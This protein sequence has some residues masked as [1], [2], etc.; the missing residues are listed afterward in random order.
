V[1]NLGVWIFALGG[2][3]VSQSHFFVSDVPSLFWH[4]L[5]VYLLLLLI[6]Q[7]EK[8]SKKEQLLMWSAF[9]F[10]VAFGLK[11]FLV[12]LPSL[13]LTTMVYRIRFQKVINIALFFL[14]GFVI[15]N[16]AD[17]T[18]YIFYKTMV[19]GVS[20]P[21]Q[22]SR[23]SSFF[24]YV[25][26]L[27][28][29]V[30][31]PVAMLS[32]GGIYFLAKKLFIS[33][34]PIKYRKTVFI[35]IVPILTNVL[36]IVFK[37]D[38]F[39]R[40]LI[41]LIPWMSLVAG[42]S[43]VQIADNLRFKGMPA[44]LLIIL[45]FVYLAVFIFDAERVFLQEPRN[46]AA[47]WLQHNIPHGTVISWQGHDWLKS[48]KHVPFPEMGR[49]QVIVMEMHTANHYLSGMSWKDSY[50]ED[51]RFIFA[52]RSQE[53]VDAI[54]SLFK[55]TSEYR[56]VIKFS[57]GYFMPEYTLVDN[58]IGNRSRNYIAEIVIFM[59]TN[60]D[61]LPQCTTQHEEGIKCYPEISTN[62]KN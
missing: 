5:G 62:P 4:L 7:E 53:R 44:G 59:S 22:F 34:D 20:D 6:D 52:S 55:G 41:P 45:F 42:W 56:E 1:A 60:A 15:V 37:L 32:I 43:L 50:P 18:P 51:Y 30:S 11:L 61:G 47:K 38:H 24:L 35:V 17:Y 9:C 26:E 23:L 8:E 31:L 21:Y 48:H 25:I 14:C 29:V 28:S 12:G 33:S 46:E 54:Q 16:F 10:G 2:L 49:P 13:I 3:H 27:P 40:H 36:F 57:E 39:P 19:K 58:L